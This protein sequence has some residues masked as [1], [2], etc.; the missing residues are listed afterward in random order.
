MGIIYYVGLVEENMEKE[1]MELK[2][3]SQ[4]EIICELDLETQAGSPLAPDLDFLG[5]SDPN[6]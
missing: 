5:L 4:P 3:Y 2:S 6:G 1:Q